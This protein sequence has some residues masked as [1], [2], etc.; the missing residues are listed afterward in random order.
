M[1]PMDS[2]REFF[3]ARA[4]NLAKVHEELNQAVNR[5]A[6]F[7]SGD[8]WSPDRTGLR[9]ENWVPRAQNNAVANEEDEH[10]DEE[11]RTSGNVS[12]STAE[13][14][15]EAD[16]GFNNDEDVYNDY[17]DDQSDDEKTDES[18]ELSEIFGEDVPKTPPSAQEK[19]SYN[20][21]SIEDMVNHESPEPKASRLAS[22]PPSEKSQDSPDRI[23][24]SSALEEILNPCATPAT[25]PSLK[26]KRDAESEDVPA[27]VSV[28]MGREQVAV[29]VD[30]PA[31]RTRIVTH[32][33]GFFRLATATA[34]GVFMGGVGVFAALV[35]T[36]D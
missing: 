20:K 32:G 18:M 11:V 12:G 6:L 16:G 8:W 35:A 28:E 34:V 30:R 21:L 7:E 13:V 2:K 33:T 36:A 22:P 5:P 23:K 15:I 17:C 19:G 29:E 3:A 25:S 27:A 4:K 10:E 1:N 26:R 9:G 31:K 14:C 24:T